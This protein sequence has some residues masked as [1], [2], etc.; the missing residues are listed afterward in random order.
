MPSPSRLA[1][2]FLLSATVFAPPALAFTPTGNPVADKFL[3]LLKASGAQDL[4]YGSVRNSGD[5]VELGEVTTRITDQSDSFTVKI[6]TVGLAGGS[7]NGDGILTTGSFDMSGFSMT[8][9]DFALT[10]ETLDART[11]TFPPVETIRDAAMAYNASSIYESA[12]ATNAAISGSDGLYIPIREIRA[13]NADFVEN[14]PRTANM[15][16]S[17]ITV[18]TKN[19]PNSDFR[20]AMTDL[21]YEE[22]AFNV[23][24]DW[25]WDD[26]AGRFELPQFTISGND[27]AQLTWTFRLGGWTRELVTELAALNPDDEQAAQAV[28]GKMQSTT[29][30]AISLQLEDRSAVN[31]VID[32][33]AAFAN[34]PR[35]EF[36][37]RT[38]GGLAGPLAALNNPDFQN[39]IVTELRQ[40]MTD[41]KTLTIN[42]APENP[43]PI[44]QIIGMVAIAPQTLPAILGVTVEA[45]R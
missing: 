7:I 30:E 8:S 1:I 12:V 42:V 3:E 40:F 36:I 26:E 37:S 44:A 45:G 20:Q 19:L 18:S 21:G 27:F 5:R 4:A 2:V 24:T 13:T 35:E 15:N 38:V 34:L 9:E 43:I 25:K 29:I 39:M 16:V 32:N 33:R 10:L 31:R 41:P 28:L 22:V 23:V 11:V 14:I 6:G 17:D